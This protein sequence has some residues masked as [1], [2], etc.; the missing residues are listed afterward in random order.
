MHNWENRV[1]QSLEKMGGGLRTFVKVT[2]P[3]NH[4]GK[5]GIQSSDLLITGTVLGY[6]SGTANNWI[7]V[8]TGENGLLNY[9]QHLSLSTD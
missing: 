9:N 1:R 8:E 7:G 2:P 3:H 6:G 4:L 5:P